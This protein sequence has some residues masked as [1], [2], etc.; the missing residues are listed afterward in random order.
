MIETLVGAVEPLYECPLHCGDRRFRNR[1]LLPQIL[2]VFGQ[3]SARVDD[4][5]LF[6]TQ[7][8]HVSD[9]RSNVLHVSRVL[10]HRDK[11]LAPER[12]DFLGAA[13]DR[14]LRLAALF[15]G[16]TLARSNVCFPPIPAIRSVAA[17]R[18]V[19]AP[20]NGEDLPLNPVM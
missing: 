15:H 12:F 13:T 9:D 5:D 20:R 1:A 2:P 8:I 19:E 18:G 10:D 3:R 17:P 4:V 11:I 14:W 7:R 6:D 16:Q